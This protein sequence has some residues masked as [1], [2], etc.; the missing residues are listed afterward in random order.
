[1]VAWTWEAEQTL[2]AYKGDLKPGKM[3][4]WEDPNLLFPMDTPRQQLH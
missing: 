3:A 1:M 4:E 2:E